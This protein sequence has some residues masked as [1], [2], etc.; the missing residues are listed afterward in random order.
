MGTKI[1]RMLVLAALAVGTLLFSGCGGGGS[2]T[3]PTVSGVAA[4]G[5]PLTGQVSLVD[6]NG[7]AAPGAPKTLNADG[8]F[9]FDVSNMRP[10]FF[11]KADGTAGGTG[12]TMY[13]FALAAGTAN[14][15]P[16]S[17]VVC[18]A[19]AGVNDPA[20]A[21]NAPA[22]YAPA[23]T[24]PAMNTAT[25]NM[26]VMM[27]NIL[28]QFGATTVNPVTGSY[29]ANHTGLDAVFDVVRM[30]IDTG[31]GTMTVVDKT[32]G[33]SG[34]VLGAA[35][36]AQMMGSTPPAAVAAVSNGTLPTD[37]QNIAA[38]LTNLGG[39]LNKGA[40][41]TTTDLDPYFAADPGFGL[42]DG[43]TRTQQMEM[44]RTGIGSFLN[45]RTIS[46]MTGVTFM[47]NGAGGGYIVSFR[48]RL[49]DGA[50][51]M[52]N[53]TFSD[54]F[55]MKKNA[56]NQWQI[57]GNGHRSFM[58]NSM[59]NQ[60]WQTATGTRTQA[61]IHFDMSDPGNAFKAAVITGTGLPGGGIEMIKDSADPT[62]FML[63]TPDATLPGKG[64]K[65]YPMS[66]GN[67]ALMADNAPF[68]F[69]FYSSLPPRNN[70]VE[71]RVM[72]FARRCLTGTEAAATSGLY[73]AVTPA[74][75]LA[76][77]AFSTMMSNMMGMMGGSGMLTMPFAY[78]T[79][80]G[81]PVTMMDAKF[82]ISS[83]TFGDETVLGIPMNGT[84]ATMGMTAPTGSAPTSGTGYLDV[85]ATDAFGRTVATSWMYQ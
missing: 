85:R 15:N 29:S 62:I 70:P 2:S 64:D 35:T 45:G 8:S 27:T 56:G 24:L 81:L 12:Y 38:M 14:I 63:Q 3:T 79:P 51:V 73:P 36:R 42:N 37:M 65:F 69:T 55:V 25:T 53:A 46:Q 68:T 47:G 4:A 19:V 16:M 13:S 61:G 6:Q 60:Q 11:L 59:L 17:N 44:V 77:H 48:M 50:A 33:T 34:V 67:I 7:T 84:S 83:S 30:S 72:T 80:T 58:A 22:T 28:N 75:N 5:A 39:A 9:S 78:T 41:V 82:S 26:R 43:R 32:S 71:Q 54:E 1:G 10:P 18:A 31:S 40:A 23:M 52:S 76:T 74:G 21:Y 57:T 20:T 66:D 49:S